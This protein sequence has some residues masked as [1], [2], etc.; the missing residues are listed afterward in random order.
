[1]G[2]SASRLRRAARCL[3]AIAVCLTV[4]MG[5]AWAEPPRVVIEFFTSQETHRTYPVVK[6]DGVL[7]GVVS[8][9]DILLWQQ[10][11]HDTETLGNKLAE[12]DVVAGHEED[13]VGA[14][15]DLMLGANTGRVAIVNS[16]NVLIGLVTRKDLLHL[17]RNQRAAELERRPYLRSA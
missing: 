6:P 11:T 7:A 10:E 13:T 2:R 17:R 9:A 3:S 1:M 15:A 14:I 16:S 5:P 12:R 8:R 4:P